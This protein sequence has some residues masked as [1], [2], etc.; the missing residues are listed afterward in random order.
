MSRLSLLEDYAKAIEDFG[1]SEVESLLASGS[2]FLL[3][4]PT[5]GTSRCVV[6]SMLL[7]T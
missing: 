7:Q 1:S 6:S 3:L 4:Q 5:Q 2:L